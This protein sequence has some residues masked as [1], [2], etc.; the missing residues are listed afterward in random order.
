MKYYSIK[1]RASLDDKHISGGE[2]ITTEENI[3]KVVSQ[4]LKRPK[5]FDL[6]NIKI[7]KINDIK[8][9][10]KSLDV[11]TIN[12]KNHK[13]GNEIALKLLE[14]A[15]IDREIAKK[16]IDLV[17]TGAN[18]D[19]ENMRGA[20]IITK[21]GKRVEKD[22]YRGVR[23]TNVDFL[24]REKVK[25]LL[26]EKNYTERTLDALALATKNLNHPNIIAEYCISDQP[27][28]ITG[29][30]AIKNTYY[31]ITPLKEHSNPKGGRI[32]FVKDDADIEEL[33]KYLQEESFLIKGVGNLE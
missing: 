28:Y 24:N 14:E 17:H 32:Y 23:T 5:N 4:L 33:Y 21:S 11:K 26:L 19:K 30:V 9:I 29:Y 18:P 27:D 6:I 22:S 10:E 25:K 3:Q 7:E 1:M 8:F 2:R 31:R 16:Y 13:E 15:K 12:V 20:M